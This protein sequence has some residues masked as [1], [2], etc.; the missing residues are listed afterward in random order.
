MKVYYDRVKFQA[1]IRKFRKNP[2]KTVEPT[3]IEIHSRSTFCNQRCG[4]ATIIIPPQE[5][6]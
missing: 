2:S 1:E 5:S 6:P 4:E 3:V